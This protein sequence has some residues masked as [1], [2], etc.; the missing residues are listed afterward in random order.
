VVTP[1]LASVKSLDIPEQTA[2]MD[3]VDNGTMPLGFARYIEGSKPKGATDA[4]LSLRFIASDQP[5]KGVTE[6]SVSEEDAVPDVRSRR[7]G[8]ETTVMHLLGIMNR[9]HVIVT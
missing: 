1:A 6:S 5:V 7:R 8:D 2:K 9:Y 4:V 3:S